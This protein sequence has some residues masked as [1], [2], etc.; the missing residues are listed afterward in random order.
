[1]E[2]PNHLT[3]ASQLS[4]DQIMNLCDVAEKFRLQ[5]MP[6]ATV[7]TTQ[8]GALLFFEPSTRT[9]IGFTTAAWQ[10]GIKT[11]EV[12]ETKLTS[13]MSTEESLMD[14]VRTLNPLVTFFAIRHSEGSAIETI[15]KHAEC[16]VINCGSADQEHPTQALIDIYAM[17]RR[18]GSLDG[19]RITMTGALRHSR[20]A[21]SLLALLGQ[22]TEVEVTGFSELQLDFSTEEIALF[23]VRGNRY[24]HVV[25]APWGSEQVVYSAGFPPATPSG[26]FTSE[27]RRRY[28]ITPHIA[29]GLEHGAIVMNPLPRVDEIDIRVDKMPCAYYFTQNELG[30][31]MRKAIL[32]EFCVS[33]FDITT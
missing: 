2:F 24:T 7:D 15:I 22:F 3:S 10:L 17:L 29:T 25:D 20:A 12:N 8:Q 6:P 5:Q 23:Q 11:V 27:I 1:M 4:R 31:F 32:S 26:T 33:R 21:R 13:N 16:P 30:L 9:R 18:F 19:L 14:T 28:A